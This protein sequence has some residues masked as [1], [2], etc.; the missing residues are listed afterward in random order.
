MEENGVGSKSFLS[1]WEDVIQD[2]AVYRVGIFVHSYRR[3]FVDLR[4]GCL[5]KVSQCSPASSSADSWHELNVF[6]FFPSK[7]MIF[8][9]M[10]MFQSQDESVLHCLFSPSSCNPPINRRQ[11]VPPPPCFPKWKKNTDNQIT[12]KLTSFQCCVHFN[13]CCL[14]TA[15]WIPRSKIDEGLTKLSQINPAGET[16]MHE[17]LK[18]VRIHRR[19]F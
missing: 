2:V 3:T 4:D 16:Y 10:H 5:H 13:L 15:F 12:Q 8:Y 19:S 18:A 17:G 1:Y 7:W 6:V 9:C 11:V 14:Q